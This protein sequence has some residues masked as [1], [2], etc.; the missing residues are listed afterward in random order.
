DTRV[1][2]LIDAGHG[3]PVAAAYGS[4]DGATGLVGQEKDINLEVAR[5]VCDV[6]GTN[7]VMTRTGDYNVT[8][9]ERIERARAAD[10]AAFVSIHSN[11]GRT[12]YGGPE[13]WVYG[14]GSRAAGA[15]S[16]QLA[17]RI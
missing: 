13:V 14:D 8:L 15:P 17:Q 9:R 4:P 2:A 10:A 16:Q 5:R 11:T 6:L 12:D 3:G 1:A 7:S